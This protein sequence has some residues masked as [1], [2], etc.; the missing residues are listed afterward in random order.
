MPIARLNHYVIFEKHLD[1]EPSN[2]NVDIL[3]LQSNY[4][5]DEILMQMDETA[6]LFGSDM[7]CYKIDFGAS[8]DDPNSSAFA[9]TLDLDNSV[10]LSVIKP[11]N[12]PSPTP[13]LTPTP[14]VTP[15]Q[16]Q[17]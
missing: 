1:L 13:T 14:T 6:S 17:R 4:G 9:N 12:V 8:M 5:D 2:L 10:N 11:Y 3:E 16:H 7:G 15:P